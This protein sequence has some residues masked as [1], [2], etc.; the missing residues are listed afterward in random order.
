MLWQT[1][2]YEAYNFSGVATSVEYDV[3]N[4]FPIRAVINGHNLVF[5]AEGKRLPGLIGDRR[6]LFLRRREPISLSKVASFSH[7]QV[8]GNHYKSLAIQPIEYAVANGLDFFQ[9]DILKYITRIKGDKEKRLEDLQKAKHYLEMY[10]EA[11][12]LGKWPWY[13]SHA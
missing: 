10:I 6:Q 1:G 9:K 2:E 8:G 12:E 3:R 13:N 7:E 5:T 4:C 11:V